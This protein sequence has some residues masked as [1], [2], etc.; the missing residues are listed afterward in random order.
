[1]NIRERIAQALTG[2]GV[3]AG[4]ISAIQGLSDDVV[5]NLQGELVNAIQPNDYL[6]T[7]AFK[8]FLEKS[9]LDGLATE[10]KAVQ[11]LMD[12]KIAK[13]LETQ[14]KKFEAMINGDGTGGA[15]AGSGEGAGAGGTGSGEGDNPVLAAVLK[16]MEEQ[17]KI[18]ADLVAERGKQTKTDEARAAISKSQ[19]PEELQNKW[20]NR[21]DLNGEIETQVA[22]LEAE[23]LEFFGAQAGSL[24]RPGKNAQRTNAGARS[25]E[26]AKMAKNLK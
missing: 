26:L 12:K 19:L 11:S 18:I 25:N 5:A 13:A 20:F 17:N 8:A 15:G 4:A 22:E 9:G 21:I 16:K 3:E 6:K 10:N 24:Y 23:Y 2:A 1:M 14:R 7:D